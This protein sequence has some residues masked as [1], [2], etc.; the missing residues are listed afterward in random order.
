MSQSRKP[1][2]SARATDRSR[3]KFMKL[4]AAGSAA[5]LAAPAAT[6]AA[7]AK[8]ARR[9]GHPASAAPAHGEK[10]A[11]R[12]VATPAEIEKQKKYVAEALKAIRNFELPPGSD[13]AFVFAPL[14]PRRARKEG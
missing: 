3:R 11:P 8:A 2:A 13:Q 5:A 10:S 9:A 4:V 1:S 12:F 7:T 6:L 14:R